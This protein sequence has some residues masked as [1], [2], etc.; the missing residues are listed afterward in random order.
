MRPCIA[1]AVVKGPPLY[2]NPG[3]KSSGFGYRKSVHERLLQERTTVHFHS[4][5]LQS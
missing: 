1:F 4:S 2:E 3:H 5:F